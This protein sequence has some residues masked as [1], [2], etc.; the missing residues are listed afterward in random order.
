MV[1]RPNTGLESRTIIA[2][3][4]TVCDV[5]VGGTVAKIDLPRA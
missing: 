4:E 2:T 3:V 5:C 1:G